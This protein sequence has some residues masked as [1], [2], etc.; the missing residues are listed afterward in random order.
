MRRAPCVSLVKGS[1]SERGRA[2]DHSSTARQMAAQ[3]T[4]KLLR[5]RGG[6]LSWRWGNASLK[7]PCVILR[8]NS[9]STQAFIDGP[10]LCEESIMPIVS[11]QLP[12]YMYQR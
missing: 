4:L 9:R 7:K 10:A 5:L 1:D 11:G 6:T 2:Y 8:K 3:K 12:E